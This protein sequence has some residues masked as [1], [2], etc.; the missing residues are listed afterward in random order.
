[1]SALRA[2]RERLAT[3]IVPGLICLLDVTRYLWAANA[4]PEAAASTRAN[5][6]AIVNFFK[7]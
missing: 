1:V 3:L 6:T 7:E 2:E 5:A 4:L